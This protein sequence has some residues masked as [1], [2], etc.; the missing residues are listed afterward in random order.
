[1]KMPKLKIKVE[2]NVLISNKSFMDFSEDA[3]KSVLDHMGNIKA[4]LE[5]RMLAA[6]VCGD[7]ISELYCSLFGDDG[8]DFEVT[9]EEI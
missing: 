8:N 6:E 2:R 9:E 1:M 3:F 7:V 5:V 4:P